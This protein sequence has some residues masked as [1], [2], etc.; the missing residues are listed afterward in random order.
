MAF[1]REKLLATFKQVPDFPKPGVV[2]QDLTPVLGHAEAFAFITEELSDRAQRWG[3]THLAAIESRGF[4]LA[5]ALAQK[6]QCGMS[7][8]RKPGKLPRAVYRESFS[9]EYGE[10]S[11][12]LHQDSIPESAKVAIVDD[13]LATGGTAAAAHRLI[14]NTKASL[15]GALFLMEIETLRGR[16]QI[17]PIEIFSLLRV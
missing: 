11:L 4:I 5:A 10:D 9:L 15:V 1:N 8:L 3:V 16:E 17:A 12:E 2:F 7:L 13:V 6:L 14:N